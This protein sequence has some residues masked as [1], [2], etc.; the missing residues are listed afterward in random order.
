MGVYRRA[1]ICEDKHVPGGF[2][3]SV[4]FIRDV[5]ICCLVHTA[6]HFFRNPRK[7][8]ELPLMLREARSTE[9][10]RPR[11]T[12]KVLGHEAEPSEETPLIG[13]EATAIEKY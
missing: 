9:S 4:L 6:D 11:A 2:S 10:R 5:S 8:R 7:R 1:I 13:K 3:S 12:E